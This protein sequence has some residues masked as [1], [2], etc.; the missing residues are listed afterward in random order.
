MACD[1]S[2]RPHELLNLKVKGYKIKIS[3]YSIHYAEVTVDGIG[4]FGLS[5]FL[6]IESL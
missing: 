2:S 6:F 1:T 3:S 5:L 4:G